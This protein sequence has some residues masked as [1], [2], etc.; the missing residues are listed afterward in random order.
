VKLDDTDATLAYEELA[1][2]IAAGTLDAI[3][4]LG[5]EVGGSFIPWS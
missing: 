4:A 5:Y 2:C 3:T 1:A